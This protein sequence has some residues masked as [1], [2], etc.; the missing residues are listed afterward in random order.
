MDGRAWEHRTGT[1]QLEL[2]PEALLFAFRVF[3]MVPGYG[4]SSENWLWQ[5]NS[6]KAMQKFG[7]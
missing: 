7:E 2:E 4:H 6:E 1:G 5:L 3:D